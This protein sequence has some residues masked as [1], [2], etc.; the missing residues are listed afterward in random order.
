[1]KYPN[2]HSRVLLTGATGFIGHYLLAEL[3]AMRVPCAVLLRAPV[4]D[5]AQ[6]LSKLLVALGF[7]LKDECASGLVVILEGDLC[8][9]LPEPA[10]LEISAIVHAAASTR[11]DR[12][13]TG[14]PRRTNV[15][16]TLTLLRWAQENNISNFHLVSS[17]Y[18]CGVID[19]SVRE[20]LGSRTPRFHNTYEKTKWQ[21][22]RACAR[23]AGAAP[24]RSL[25]IYRPSIVVGEHESGRATKFSGF[26]L[27]ARATQMLAEQYDRDPGVGD[28]HR[29]AMRV[30]GRSHDRQNM[31]PVDY[32]SAM[33]AHGVCDPEFHGGIFHLTHPDPPTNGQ[34]KHAVELRY[35]IAG[36]RFV[37]PRTFD[38]TVMNE[39]ERLFYEVSQPIEHYFV[40]TPTF[41]RTTADRLEQAAGV[42]CP[43]YDA[44]SLDR[45]LAYAQ[46]CRWGRLSVEPVRADTHTN[47]DM[48]YDAYFMSYL[49]G[50]VGRSK[51][52]RLTGLSV[53]MRFI[54]E[55]VPDGQWVCRF[56]RGLLTAVH[57]GENTYEEDFSYRTHSDVFWRAIGGGVHPQEVFF[58][59]KAEVSGDT[60]Q[61]LKMAMILHQFNKEFPCNRAIL[62]R[63]A[64]PV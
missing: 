37:D 1:M 57:R 20:S 32:V 61:A 31:V 25:T 48:L 46:D 44:D 40:D 18:R 26:Y 36:G 62:R 56:E 9:G 28:R 16:G 3:I 43:V 54:L 64:V 21:A 41:E 10:S 22:E 27:S 23:W 11:F 5:S 55:D 52:S 19:G 42:T 17:A 50:R 12:D 59:R 4:E 14:E 45:L 39:K 53:T 51:I 60:E 58:D 34:I 13:A 30:R 63:E 24:G 15:G 2:H 38:P 49:P 33:V 35:D 29:I 6:R 7:D 47:D 8:Y